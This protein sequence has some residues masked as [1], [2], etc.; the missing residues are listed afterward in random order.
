MLL[1]L[2]KL[3]IDRVLSLEL[4]IILFNGYSLDKIISRIFQATI[5]ERYFY[6]ERNG[7]FK[8]ID[9]ERKAWELTECIKK[10]QSN[11]EEKR[12]SD[13]TVANLKFFIGIRNKIEHRYWDSTTLDISLFGECQSLLY[14]YE[15]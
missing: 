15:N 7:R 10:Y 4:K 11:T 12:L 3:I 2:W 9:G 6:K 13:A 1:L 14:N 5:G 8:K